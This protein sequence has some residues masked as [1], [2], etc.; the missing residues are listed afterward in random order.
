MKRP[1][2]RD[3][4]LGDYVIRVYTNDNFSG[5]LKDYRLHRNRKYRF[6]KTKNINNVLKLPAPIFCQEVIDYIIDNI[7]KLHHINIRLECVKVTEQELRKS[8][9]YLLNT[10]IERE[11]IFKRVKHEN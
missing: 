8:K 3:I 4:K 6:N 1:S 10:I 5:Y 2:N 9:L 11:G 7:D